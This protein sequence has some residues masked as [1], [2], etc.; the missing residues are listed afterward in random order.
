MRVPE[1]EVWKFT[2]ELLCSP[3]LCYHRRLGYL[4]SGQKCWSPLGKHWGTGEAPACSRLPPGPSGWLRGCRWSCCE[5]SAGPVPQL[6]KGRG[7]HAE[8]DGA[9][10]EAWR[11]MHSIL[12]LLICLSPPELWCI[13]NINFSL[14]GVSDNK[15]CT[16]FTGIKFNNSCS[17]LLGRWFVR[18][19]SADH[20]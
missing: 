9:Q 3:G 15:Q 4:P 12:S 8:E 19:F 5:R 7:S 10:S 18:M 2:C 16:V 6:R 20:L 14:N 17:L 1:L 11:P 13:R